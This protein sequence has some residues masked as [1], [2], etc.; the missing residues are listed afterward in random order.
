MA[1]LGQQEK[2]TW[3]SSSSLPKS[4]IDDFH[5]GL[6][7]NELVNTSRNYGAIN[8]T[9]VMASEGNP[10][11]VKKIKQEENTITFDSG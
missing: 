7:S 4:L 2:M 9:L 11:K 5:R 8:H 6:S 10:P 3:E 1:W